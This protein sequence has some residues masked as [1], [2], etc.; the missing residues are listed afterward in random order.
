MRQN[1]MSSDQDYGFVLKIIQFPL[2]KQEEIKFS[3]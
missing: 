1:K 3:G 2:E